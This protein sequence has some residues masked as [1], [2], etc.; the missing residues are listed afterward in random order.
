VTKHVSVGVTVN[1]DNYENLRIEVEGEDAEEVVS[2]LDSVLAGLG[3]ND[4]YATERID[5]YRRRI[6]SHP[7]SA[8]SPSPKVV[9]ATFTKEQVAPR[10]DEPKDQTCSA[11]GD[12]ITKSQ[13]KLSHLVKGKALCKKCMK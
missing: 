13:S 1:L 5:S 9:Q 10:E 12:L 3:R 11:C 4:S 7:V 6:L 8:A 2:L